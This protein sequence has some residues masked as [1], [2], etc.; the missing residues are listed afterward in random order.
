[1]PGEYEE[2]SRFAQD[3]VFGRKMAELKGTRAKST[4]PKV[5]PSSAWQELSFGQ[6]PAVSPDKSALFSTQQPSGSA[7]PVL[8]PK[9]EEEIERLALFDGLT[10]FY[11][12]RTFTRQ[13]SYELKRGMRYKRPVALCVITI[14]GFE[15]AARQY[16]DKI[17]E[18]LLK[19]VASEARHAI[20]DVDIPARYSASELAIVFPETNA[21]GATVV[22]ERIRKK[23]G[24]K[25]INIGTQSLAITLSLGVAAFPTH[26]REP[27]DLVQRAFQAL[28]LA[29]QRGGDRLCIL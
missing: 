4:P 25:V 2:K 28:E 9:S 27:K 29:R 21:S 16:G 18:H 19:E 1:M 17:A 13:L 26:A 22:A 11:N 5:Q 23:V 20:R 10:D 12:L 8:I 7:T 14:D 6:T 24:A 15:N 3:S